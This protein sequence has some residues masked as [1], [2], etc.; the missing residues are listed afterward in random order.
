MD[1]SLSRQASAIRWNS[2]SAR[3]GICRRPRCFFRKAL[4]RHG[5]P[6]RV[7]IDSSQTNQEAIRSCDAESRL[8]DRSRRTPKPIRIRT[9]RYFNNR[10]EQ[11]H[12]R[13]KRRIRSMLGFKSTATGR[14][15]RTA[16]LRSVEHDPD[17]ENSHDRTAFR[18]LDIP[19]QVSWLFGGSGC[20]C[21]TRTQPG[22]RFPLLCSNRVKWRADHARRPENRR[23]GACNRAWH[24]RDFR[25][26]SRRAA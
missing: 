7:V 19:T 3:I 15:A 1:V 4:Q 11:D 10:I 26:S 6:D 9:S 16:V 13:V 17:V 8:R 21:D 24:V 20:G 14:R 23:N 18:S 22:R 5:R 2:I 25:C 12:R